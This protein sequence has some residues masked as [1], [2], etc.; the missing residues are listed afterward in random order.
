M[1]NQLKSAPTSS[2]ITL[3][4]SHIKLHG[5]GRR[6]I[7]FLLGKDRMGV[8]PYLSS[9]LWGRLSGFVLFWS[10]TRSLDSFN[11]I[12]KVVSNQTHRWQAAVKSLETEPRCNNLTWLVNSASARCTIALHIWLDLTSFRHNDWR[13]NNNNKARKWEWEGKMTRYNWRKTFWNKCSGILEVLKFL[14]YQQPRGFAKCTL[15]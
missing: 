10:E 12:I 7:C 2:D 3:T 5:T 1:A 13:C 11:Y 9:P 8:Q 14:S 6:E 15:N 4:L